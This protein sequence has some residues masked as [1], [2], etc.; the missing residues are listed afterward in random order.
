MADIFLSHSSADNQAAD[1]VKAWLARDRPSWS[2]FLDKHPNDG[3]L[4]GQGWQ[5]RLRAELT[6]CRL[7]LAIITPEWLA[8]RWCFT[9][10]VTADFRGKDFLPVLPK[11]LAD[12][13]F[14]AAPPILNTN[15]RC[16]IDLTTEAGWRDILGGTGKEAG[17]DATLAWLRETYPAKAYPDIDPDA[18]PVCPP[19]PAGWEGLQCPPV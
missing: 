6:S 14:A 15:Q 17:L 11:A 3:I 1:T 13:A 18:V 12:E 19:P 16:V 8:S 5:D 2:V 4:A 10:A 7:V 9:E